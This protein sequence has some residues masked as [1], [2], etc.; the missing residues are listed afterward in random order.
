[1]FIYIY[2]P[3]SSTRT[4]NFTW[5]N[6]ELIK[7]YSLLKRFLTSSCFNG[8]IIKCIQVQAVKNK[9][10]KFNT[11]LCCVILIFKRKTHFLQSSI[12]IYYYLQSTTLI[13]YKLKI[14]YQM[15]HCTDCTAVYSVKFQNG[16]IFIDNIV[17]LCYLHL[18]H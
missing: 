15:S 1:M 14:G 13:K 7:S 17:Y 16:C 10:N 12:I 2:L 18:T 3:D 4:G 6:T 11:Q 8:V 5:L 9:P